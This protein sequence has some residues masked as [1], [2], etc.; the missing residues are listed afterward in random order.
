MTPAQFQFTHGT[1]SFENPD[2]CYLH[3]KRAEG[4]IPLSSIEE[5]LQ[6]MRN[7][8]QGRKSYLIVTTEEG[9]KMTMEARDFAASNAFEDV[10]LADAIILSNY[11]HE[12]AANFFVR[13]SKPNRPV[14]LFKS[15]EEAMLWIDTLRASDQ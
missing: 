10:V 7:E 2:L 9:A 6:V 15:K 4:E 5:A 12:I 1:V 3:F 13:F 14:E 8:S 11:D